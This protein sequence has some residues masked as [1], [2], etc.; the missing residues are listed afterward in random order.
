[1]FEVLKD[2]I[3]REEDEKPSD[4]VI[5]LSDEKLVDA[6]DR[7]DDFLSSSDEAE[8]SETEALGLTDEGMRVRVRS[9]W[10]DEGLQQIDRFAEQSFVALQEK[11]APCP[12][13]LAVLISGGLI[14]ASLVAAL[15][16]APG[17]DNAA[18]ME[19]DQLV[20]KHV[21]KSDEIASGLRSVQMPLPDK[22]PEKEPPVREIET[23]TPVLHFADDNFSTAR[24]EIQVSALDLGPVLASLEEP[25]FIHAD[26]DPEATVPSLAWPDELGAEVISDEFRFG[27]PETDL[28]ESQTVTG[29]FL[30]PFQYDGVIRHLIAMPLTNPGD[31]LWNVSRELGLPTDDFLGMTET[32]EERFP[33]YDPE[34]LQVNDAVFGI[35]AGTGGMDS[36][37]TGM[38]LVRAQ[39]GLTEQALSC[40][41]QPHHLYR[42]LKTGGN[43]DNASCAALTGATFFFQGVCGPECA[44]FPR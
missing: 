26:Y 19:S 22:L 11:K 2:V 43:T 3:T 16:F 10:G 44:D 41:Q 20:P 31:N 32:L 18:S 23:E 37:I 25:D 36:E 39:S 4:D 24:S 34:R 15:Y 27:A 5:L 6:L 38:L 29:G 1:M 33:T 14:A 13:K 40:A 9:L 42:L 28:V 17:T 21:V 12:W 7:L 35:S 8:I 30:R